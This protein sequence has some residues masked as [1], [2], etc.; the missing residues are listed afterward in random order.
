VPRL[1]IVLGIAF[2]ALA[3]ATS[4]RAQTTQLLPGV[5][6]E[7]D[8]QFTA[9]GPVAIHVVRGPRPVGLYRLRPALSN[10]TVTGR[11]TLSAMERR[12]S[13]QGT[14]IGINGDFFSFKD[15]HPSGMLLRDDT[16]VT[17]PL[18]ARSSMGIT[19]GGMIDIRRVRL[20]GRWRGVGQDRILNALNASPGTNGV[21]LFTSDYGPATPRIPGASAVVLSPFPSATLNTDVVAPV[22]DTLQSAAVQLVPGTAVL[23]ARGAAAEKLAAEAPLGANVTLRLA[24]SPDWPDVV[25]AIGGGPIL[26]RDGRPVFDAGEGFTTSQLAPR[27]PR[28]AIG[29]MADGRLLLVAVDGREA[30]YS[31]GL[32]NFELAQTMMRL[33]ALR[34]MALDSGGSTTLAFNG[35]VLNRPSDGR[36][37]PIAT[38]LMLLYSGVYAAPPKVDVVSPNDDGVDDRQL[39]AY[40]VVHPSSVTVTL[41][42]P[43]STVAFEQTVEQAPGTYRV[44]FPPAAAGSARATGEREGRWALTVSAIDD[45]DVSSSATRTFS[46][47]STVG[48]LRLSTRALLVPP[49][50]R[51]MRIG[52]TQTRMARITVRVVTRQGVVLRRVAQG[53][54]E[55]GEHS[56][57][58]NGIRKDGRRAY[59]GVYRVVLTARNAVGT[60]S[61]ERPVHVR[62][63]PGPTK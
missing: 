14:P 21:S 13:S 36:E 51:D 47:N 38:A 57:T 48:F 56:V 31:V 60:V 46:V 17:A 9:H 33:G 28:S 16:L 24:L 12:M 41:T 8:V 15:G 10:E 62:R 49:G 18:A 11:E 3:F 25:D 43:D 59:G 53:P 7:D 58:W 23:L 42:A 19:S 29:Q 55:P 40:R 30:G 32:T 50:G 26:I 4:T 6:Y 35:S 34:A 5:T 54:F 22:A 39:L 63:I 61:L 1:A 45:Q 52:W 20:S 37:R 27:H 2:L 44:A